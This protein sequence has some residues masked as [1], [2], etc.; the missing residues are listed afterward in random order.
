MLIR[1]LLILACLSLPAMAQE[2][3][4]SVRQEAQ[5]L[6]AALREQRIAAEDRSAQLA[7]HVTRLAR[8]LDAAKKSADLK[9][10]DGK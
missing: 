5:D 3:V 9:K 1:A 7:A 4:E 6:I 2:T 10:D 8:D